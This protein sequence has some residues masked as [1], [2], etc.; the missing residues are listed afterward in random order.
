[1]ITDMKT[2]FF[3]NKE[4]IEVEIIKLPRSKLND[5]VRQIGKIVSISL[6]GEFYWIKLEMN[7][8]IV[9]FPRKHFRE[10]R[11]FSKINKQFIHENNHEEIF[12][13]NEE[14]VELDDEEREIDGY[15]EISEHE[16][17]FED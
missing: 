11:R 10:I 16:E 14:Q 1:M 3:K 17:E 12:H 9:K 15:D 13:I 8:K 4:M 2:R 7:R 6:D 5:Y